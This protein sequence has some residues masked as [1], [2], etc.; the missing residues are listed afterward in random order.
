MENELKNTS[1][2]EAFEMLFTEG[3]RLTRS[4]VNKLV[5]RGER[6][7]FPLWEVIRDEGNWKS[8][9]E[10]WWAPIHA[11]FILGA[12]GGKA[13]ITPLIMSLRFSDIFDYEWIYDSLPSIFGCLGPAVLEPL[14]KIVLDL[15]NSWFIRSSA[16]EGMAAV[17]IK[18]Q[19]FSREVFDFIAQV[20]RDSYEQRDL[21]AIAG[22]ILLDFNQKKYQNSLLEFAKEDE[23]RA[24][25]DFWEF[26]NFSQDNVLEILNSDKVNLEQYTKDWL[27][28][29]NDE[30]IDKRQERWQEEDKENFLSRR[31]WRKIKGRIK[32]I[33][34]VMRFIK[35]LREEGIS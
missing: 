1:D 14:K 8:N 18:H 15:S 12:I 27:N 3:D 29:Y 28:F 32:N 13:V 4:V 25:Y 2:D 22:H 23:E 20:L 16:L 26:I 24:R 30:E 17:T 9:N 7:V 33:F 21:R 10:D 34:L 31:I 35:K 11:T 5:S 19:N 6:M